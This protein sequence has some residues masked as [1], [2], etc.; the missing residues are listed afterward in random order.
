M[1]TLV[2]TTEELD[3]YVRERVDTVLVN[4]HTNS[5]RTLHIES[6]EN[7]MEPV[8]GTRAQYD[9]L[10]KPITVYPSNYFPICPHCAETV[11]DIE[12]IDE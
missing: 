8:C 5:S 3:A 12:V 11:F 10:D 6:E 2:L 9:W 1:T 4:R 7:W